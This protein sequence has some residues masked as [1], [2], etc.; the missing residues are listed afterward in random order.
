M[1]RQVLLLAMVAFACSGGEGGA[2]APDPGPVQTVCLP[3]FCIDYPADWVIELGADFITLEHPLGPMASVGSI[4][5]E[6]VA[7]GAGTPWPAD[8]VDTM[9]SFW[10][11][12]D[13]L[14]DADLESITSGRGGVVDTEG[15]LDGD[16]L[17][18]RLMPADPP[19]AWGA[20]LRAPNRGWAS[21]A[22]IIVGSLREPPGS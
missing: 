11:L 10:D 15:T 3:E 1:R 16:R 4:D 6:G 17:W 20:E 19:K 2:V 8:G 14:G 22:A 18:H 9:R 5:A 13:E 7:R 21:H 12:L